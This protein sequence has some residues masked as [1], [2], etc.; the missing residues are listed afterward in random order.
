LKLWLARHA[1]PLIA[2]GIC[3][4]A[5]DVPADA[6]A[7]LDAAQTLSLSLPFGL[8]VSVS[9][10]QRCELLKHSLQALRPD[11]VFKSDARL[12]EMNFGTWEGQRWD[13]IPQIE[14]E[15]WTDHFGE[16]AC[17]GAERVDQFMGRVGEV[18]DEAQV[19]GQDTVWIT[20]AGVIRAATL[21]SQG[22]RAIKQAHKWPHQAPGFGEWCAL[23]L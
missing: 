7:T 1:Q 12:A 20:H 8:W 19:L 17:G 23:D 4:G 21:L 6:Q 22:I 14:L 5:T 15:R 2:P 13:A 9:P 16:Y 10:L 11:L 18:W 3:Y